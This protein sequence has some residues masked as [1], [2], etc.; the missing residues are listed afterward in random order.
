MSRAS[1]GRAIVNLLQ[2]QAGENITSMIPVRNFDKGEL[3][4][5]TERGVVKKTRLQ[6]FSHPQRGGIIAIK[7][8]KKDTLIR[9]ELTPGGDDVILGTASG[10]AIRFPAEQVRSMGRATHG[11]KG[12]K[13]AKDDKVVDMVMVP[14][15]EA[16]DGTTLLSICENGFGKRTE[17]AEYRSQSRGGKGLINI[18]TSKRNGEVVSLMTV[19]EEDEVMLITQGGMVIRVPA[20]SIRQIS[21][22]TQGVKLISL[23]TDDKLVAAARVAKGDNEPEGAEAQPAGSEEGPKQRKKTKGRKKA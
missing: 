2:L 5:A 21:R 10:K 20:G 22:N 19:G 12:I 18:K 1:K 16:E 17:I 8:D 14:S 23:K 7:L 15:R 13:L 11:V 3:I 9:V 6:A 4:M